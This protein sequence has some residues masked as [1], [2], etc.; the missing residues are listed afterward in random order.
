[1][2][3]NRTSNGP[4]SIT[5]A[6]AELGPNIQIL[7]GA[8]TAVGDMEAAVP[9][10]VALSAASRLPNP[11]AVTGAPSPSLPSLAPVCQFVGIWMRF[12]E[13]SSVVS[14]H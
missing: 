10:R 11:H 13:Y 7:R 9:S 1:M 14:T 3:P 6:A 12:W 8:A 4:R 2:P 5:T